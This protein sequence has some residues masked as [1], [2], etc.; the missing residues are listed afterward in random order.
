LPRVIDHF[1]EPSGKQYLVM[2]FVDGQ[3][4]QEKLESGGPIAEADAVTWVRQ[5]GEALAYLHSRPTP[6]IHRDIK[7]A[8]IKL[9]RDGRAL[10]VDFGIAKQYDPSKKTVAAARAVT[11]G[12]SPPE[13][14][15]GSITDPRSDIYAL[16]AT[17]YAM[18]TCQAPPDA[19]DRITQQAQLIAPRA[20]NPRLSASVEAAVMRAMDLNPVNRPQSMTDFLHLL[21][22]GSSPNSAP[23]VLQP[24]FPPPIASVAPVWSANANVINPP[25]GGTPISSPPVYSPPVNQPWSP[26]VTG[27][28]PYDFASFGQRV[29]AYVIDSVIVSFVVAVLLVVAAMFQSDFVSLLA[30]GLMVFF[31]F[32]YFIR[33]HAT[34]GQTIGKR[35]MGIQVVA[36]DG[37]IIS[38]KRAFGRLLV[39]SLESGLSFLIIPLFGFLAMLWD[40]NGQTW[41][42]KVAGTYVVRK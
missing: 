5:V 1:I 20:L 25:L 24:A 17:L 41:H 37:S 36:T 40:T 13:Q 42:D 16:G 15:G 9:A 4:L 35:A 18:L 22:L 8:N 3:D 31:S 11:S 26:P 38:R 29:V 19:M 34:T 33:G 2:D 23:A 39:L 7:P 28:A 21:P 10:L 12:F 6:I 30:V 32:W 14:Y 27:M